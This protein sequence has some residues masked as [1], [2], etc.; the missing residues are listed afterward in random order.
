[1][2]GSAVDVMVVINSERLCSIS[3]FSFWTTVAFTSIGA[4]SGVGSFSGVFFLMNSRLK[5]FI[6]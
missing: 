3:I 2:T 6:S 4:V 5:A 1:M